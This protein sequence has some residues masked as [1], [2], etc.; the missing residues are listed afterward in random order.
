M[1]PSKIH[2]YENGSYV[3]QPSAYCQRIDK[4]LLNG[5]V[6]NFGDEYFV[7]KLHVKQHC[8]CLID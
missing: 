3:C 7:G 8:L 6:V 2:L 1:I 5:D 4:P